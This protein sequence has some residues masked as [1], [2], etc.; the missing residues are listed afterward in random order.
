MQLQ[1]AEL[2]EQ[3]LKV[4]TEINGKVQASSF[5]ITRQHMLG[6]NHYTIKGVVESFIRELSL[7]KLN[8]NGC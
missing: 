3:S 7:K 6:L 4:N 5:G 1:C 2:K 8:Q